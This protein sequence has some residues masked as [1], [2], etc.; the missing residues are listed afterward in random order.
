M[1]NEQ[2]VEAYRMRLE[3]ATLQ[4]IGDTFGVSKEYIRQIIP[5][6]EERSWS[7]RSALN[8]CVYPN[9]SQWLVENRC[10]YAKFSELIGAPDASVSRWMNG[11]HKLSKPT[12]DRILKVTGMTYEQAFWQ[13]KN[14]QPKMAE[15]G[16]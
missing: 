11:I 7:T 16:E 12:I 13:E 3:G 4:T 15:G 14:S 2:K 8:R 5:A 6:I 9:I 1:T 10:T